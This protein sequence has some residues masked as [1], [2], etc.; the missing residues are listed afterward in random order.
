MAQ[1]KAP[2]Y[3]DTA[4]E[5]EETRPSGGQFIHSTTNSGDRGKVADYGSIRR[6]VRA[7]RMRLPALVNRE[8]RCPSSIAAASSSA[9]LIYVS[10]TSTS[11]IPPQCKHSTFNVAFQKDCKL[12]ASV[13][14]PP[15]FCVG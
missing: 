6:E 8:R 1:S 14:M 5:C 3:R 10:R 4:R 11:C 15:P 2:E 12:C 13:S 7:P 9:L